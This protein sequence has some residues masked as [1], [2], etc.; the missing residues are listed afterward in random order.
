MPGQPGLGVG[1][2]QRE[3][4]GCS[5]AL[6]LTGWAGKGTEECQVAKPKQGSPFRRPPQPDLVWGVHGGG[7]RA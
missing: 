1:Y 7:G 3:A 6:S 2:G 5:Q 4:A